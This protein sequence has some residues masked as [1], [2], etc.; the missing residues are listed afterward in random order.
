MPC[1]CNGNRKPKINGGVLALSLSH[2]DK[3][4]ISYRLMQR[5]SYSKATNEHGCWTRWRNPSRFGPRLIEVKQYQYVEP[6]QYALV[7]DEKMHPV[8]NSWSCPAGCCNRLWYILPSS[9][10]CFRRHSKE[11]HSS[12]NFICFVSSHVYLA[13]IVY[14]TWFTSLR[15]WLRIAVASR[16]YYYYCAHS[17]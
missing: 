10:Y 9:I 7:R 17:M 1:H 4:D 15:V 8:I 11:E 14:Q 2:W 12:I 3:W 13:S 6:C 16:S 5:T